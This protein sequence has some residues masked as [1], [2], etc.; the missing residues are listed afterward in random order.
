MG[1]YN[2]CSWKSICI[3]YE[4]IRLCRLRISPFIYR[5]TTTP[6]QTHNAYNV[7]GLTV[8]FCKNIVYLL[9]ICIIMWARNPSSAIADNVLP[10]SDQNQYRHCSDIILALMGFKLWATHLFMQWLF[11]SNNK[12]NITAPNCWSS[13]GG[14]HR[15]QEMWKAC[16]C[17][18]VFMREKAKRNDNIE[19]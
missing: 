15:C 16:P 13:E 12:E 14:N 4:L 1:V 2:R 6:Y 3:D 18:D 9:D 10:W 8:I 17:H 11:R 19:T 5:I 7:S